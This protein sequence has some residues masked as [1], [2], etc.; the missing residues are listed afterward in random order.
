MTDDTH[1]MTNTELI[2]NS[3]GISSKIYSSRII[4]N[5][6]F[7]LQ[8]NRLRS[9]FSG[10]S[11]Y[12]QKINFTYTYLVSGERESK[13]EACGPSTDNDDW[14]FFHDYSTRFYCKLF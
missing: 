12:K 13:N 3:H 8:N 5:S 2:Q 4:T 7:L 9:N 14:N 11:G 6:N 1:V 10:V